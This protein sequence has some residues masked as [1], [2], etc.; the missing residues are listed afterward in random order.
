MATPALAQFETATIVGV[1][2]DSTGAVVPGA[3][4]TL[5]NTATGVTAERLSDANGNYEFFTVRIGN[6][7]I[8]AEKTGVSLPALALPD[9]PEANIQ[10]VKPHTA[11]LKEWLPM[12]ML[13][14]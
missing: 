9:V 1:V 2:K 12:A 4:V 14:L 8:T 5:T 6:Y 3:K 13:G 7:L 11:K 10:L